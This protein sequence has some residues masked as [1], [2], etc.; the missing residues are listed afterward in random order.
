MI[1]TG[2]TL[3]F[4]NQ[5]SLLRR[6]K[7]F[8][9]LFQ[10]LSELVLGIFVNL[11][12]H[13]IGHIRALLDLNDNLV[14]LDFLY[15]KIGQNHP[16]VTQIHRVFI[17]ITF[18][19]VVVVL[20]QVFDLLEDE[21]LKEARVLETVSVGFLIEIPFRLFWR[22]RFLLVRVNL[23]LDVWHLDHLVFAHSFLEVLLRNHFLPAEV[24]VGTFQIPEFVIDVFH[25][26]E[27][28]EFEAEFLVLLHMLSVVMGNLSNEIQQ[29]DNSADCILEQ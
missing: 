14:V 4:T 6:K 9:A 13:V 12:N 20:E 29:L 19:L 16:I 10:S 8:V 2:Q 11:L 18:C 17:K 15:H 21:I 7:D 5:N 25:E 24:R 22:K 1:W 3:W 28:G 23:E 26:V 27:T